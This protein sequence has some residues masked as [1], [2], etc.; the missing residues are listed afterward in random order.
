MKSL[1]EIQDYKSWIKL[2]IK[3][4]PHGG[5]GEISRM[6]QHLG[7][8]V[9]LV[10]QILK[11][12]KDFTIEQ[13]YSLTEYFALNDLEAEFFVVL[14]QFNRAGT[15]GLRKF[16]EKRMGELIQK[17]QDLKKRLPFDRQL[18]TEE[19]ATFYSDWR[20][21][22]VRVFT[23]LEDGKTFEEIQKH[24]HLSIQQAHRIVD[25]L[26]STGLCEKKNNFYH[27]GSQQTHVAF[28]SPFLKSHLSNWRNKAV[29]SSDGLKIEELMYSSCLSLSRKDFALIKERLAEVVKSVQ[30]A[31]KE[32]DPQEL[33]IFNLDWAILK[34]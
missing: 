15:H 6:A 3:S 20:F 32:T 33:V 27:V 13:G 17:S 19:S 34:P 23:S 24:F 22:A 18:S 16:F 26:V 5:R 7:V 25:F 1:F 21:S 9:T 4:L 8:H 12:D 30:L 10:S 2:R 14:I 11:G 31:V 29:E 28:G